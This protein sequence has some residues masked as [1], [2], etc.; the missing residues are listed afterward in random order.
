MIKNIAFIGLG[1]MGTP[2]SRHLMAAGFT[3]SGYDV[4]DERMAALQATVCAPPHRPPTQPGT[5][6]PSSPC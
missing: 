2:I 4:V 5:P 3:V 6:T 1:N